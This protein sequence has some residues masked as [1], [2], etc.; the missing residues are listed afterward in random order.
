MRIAFIG[1]KGIPVSQGGVERH[2]EELARHLAMRGHE[3]IAYG[4]STYKTGDTQLP[5]NVRVITVPSIPVKAWDTI[6]ATMLSTIDVLFRKVDVVHFHSLGPAFFL[7]LPWL[8]KPSALTV[9]THHTYETE[10]P[11]WGPLARFA[12]RL[13]EYIG[14]YFADEVIAISPTVAMDLERRF[15]RRVS[16]VPNGVSKLVEGDG[17]NEL[18]LPEKYILVVSRLIRSKGIDHLI[19]AF[20]LIQADYPDHHLVIVGS[21]THNDNDAPRL[22]SL[23]SGNANVHF[24]GW[25]P[26]SRLAR[27]YKK[28]AV[29]VQPSEI[30]GLPITLLEAASA[31]LPI[32]TSDIPEHKVVVRS[33]ALTFRSGNYID[34]AAKLR[35]LLSNYSEYKLLAARLAKRIDAEFNWEKISGRV[36]KV[37]S[38]PTDSGRD[39]V[40]KVA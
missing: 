12:M 23:A 24:L 3:I 38:Y 36:E 7:I 21:P 40:A 9:F 31:G 22:R 2:V 32:I 34:L 14:M 33:Q 1:Q 4:R 35:Y 6:I 30:E 19:N 17:A 28:A 10:R 5:I 18:I 27:I 13:G 8:F 16:T 26:S 25:Q 20:N 37:Y 39:W 11:Q 15:N 29:F